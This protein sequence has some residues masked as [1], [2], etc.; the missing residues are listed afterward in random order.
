[1]FSGDAIKPGSRAGARSPR[2]RPR[3]GGQRSSGPAARNS[4]S[5]ILRSPDT[6]RVT[7]ARAL[8]REHVVLELGL[9]LRGPRV[10]AP[11]DLVAGA[12]VVAA[13]ADDPDQ[14]VLVLGEEHR[15]AV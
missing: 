5:S 10:D 11:V 2:R 13:D 15:A 1:M 9:V 4:P 7:A 6:G 12:R 3:T 8:E 14:A